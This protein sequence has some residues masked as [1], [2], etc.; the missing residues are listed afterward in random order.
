MCIRRNC[1]IAIMVYDRTTARWPCCCCPEDI[2]FEMRSVFPAPLAF[3]CESFHL[4]YYITSVYRADFVLLP[5][6][7]PFFGS[8]LSDGVIVITAPVF[9]QHHGL[10]PTCA[11]LSYSKSSTKFLTSKG[12]SGACCITLW[13]S[14][15]MHSTKDALRCPGIPRSN[16][17]ILNMHGRHRSF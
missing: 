16:Y 13:G 12:W 6:W 9:F 5:C 14:D 15:P 1:S 10:K 2:G 3:W 4:S 11:I 7:Q 8:V 17:T